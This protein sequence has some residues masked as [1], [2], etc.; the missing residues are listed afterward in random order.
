MRVIESDRAWRAAVSEV[1]D[2]W[3][4][5]RYASF[6]VPYASFREPYYSLNT[7]LIQS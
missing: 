3:A 1:L 7:A 4:A 2:D 6:R 5:Y